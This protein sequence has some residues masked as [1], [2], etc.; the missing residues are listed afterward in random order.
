[1]TAYEVGRLMRAGTIGLIAGCTV[2]QMETP[3][4][5][6]LVRVPLGEKTEAYGLLYDIHIDDDGLVRQLA[7][8]RHVSAEV[9]A[10]NQVN[11][12]VPVEMS[13]VS[14][15]YIRDGKIS[16]MLPPRPPLS[17]EQI[18]SCD[19]EEVCQFTSCG[20]FSYFRHILRGTDYPPS[21]L[22]AAHLK[23]ASAAHSSR[24]NSVWLEAAERELITLLRNDYP[25]LMD[26]LNAVRDI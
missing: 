3:E 10:D 11:R 20:Q 9:I 18:F 4:F 26:V 16:H 21:E 24:G 7:T 13:I 17:L 2:P 22:L 5:G 6:A 8:T 23:L 15:G 25:A 14:V 19:A 1:M 12:N